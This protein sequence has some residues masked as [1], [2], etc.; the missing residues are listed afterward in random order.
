MYP[1][2]V[3]GVQS[4]MLKGTA[5]TRASVLAIKV[6]PTPEGPRSKIFVLSRISGDESKIGGLPREGDGGCKGIGP[7]WPGNSSAF[8]MFNACVCSSP[9]I[10]TYLLMGTPLPSLSVAA[11][12][13]YPLLPLPCAGFPGSSDND[14]TLQRL[15]P[16]SPSLVPQRIDLGAV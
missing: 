2:C 7:C 12:A 1:A 4:D 13:S 6:F 11:V 15:E 10:P 8:A 5:S 3:N 14:C 16:S 9:R